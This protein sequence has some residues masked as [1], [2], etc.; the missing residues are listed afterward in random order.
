M[1]PASQTPASPSRLTL[2]ERIV[3]HTTFVVDVAK[4][5][6]AIAAIILALRAPDVLV[7]FVKYLSG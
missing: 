4:V 3:E 7:L 1:E 2:P 6:A 5:L